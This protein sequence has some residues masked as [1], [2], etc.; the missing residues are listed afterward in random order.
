LI[1]KRTKKNQDRKKLQPSG[2]TPW[3]AFLSGL[4]PPEEIKVYRLMKMKLGVT[5]KFSKGERK[6]LPEQLA[7]WVGGYLDFSSMLLRKRNE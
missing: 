7:L 4:C 3:P 5:L 2:Q 6:G 1:Q